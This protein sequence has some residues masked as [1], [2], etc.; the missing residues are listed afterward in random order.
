MSFLS[1]IVSSI[2][3][4]SLD[5]QKGAAPHRSTLELKDAAAIALLVGSL[6]AVFWR[7]IFTSDMFF[8]RDV[9]YYSYPHARFIQEACRQGTLP[10][11]NPYLNYGQPIL[12][13]PNFLFFYPDTLF[14]VLLPI[15]FAYT[16]HY[17]AHFALAGIGTYWLGRRWGQS[18]VAAFFAAFVFT[19]SGPVLSLGNFYNHVA[20]AAWVPWALLATDFAVESLSRRPWILLTLVFTLQFLA[21]EPFTLLATF[22]LSAAYALYQ[23]GTIRRPLAARGR[24]IL[25]VF[26]LV[27]CLMLALGAMALG[28]SLEL[29]S[30]SRRGTE[31]LRYIEITSWSFHPL[32]LLEVVVPDFFGPPLESLSLWTFVLSGRNMPYFPSFFVGF[33]PM[34]FALAGLALGRNRRRK[35]AAVAALIF[36]L[37]SFGRYTPLFDLAYLLVPPLELVRFPVKMLIPAV[38]LTAILAGWG[39]DA[40]RY[41]DSSLADRR[42]GVLRPLKWI[43]A[44]AALLLLIS[45]AAP[46]W[47]AAPAGWL[48]QETNRMS[49]YNPSGELSAE[50]IA[51]AKEFFLK[52][53]RIHMPGL[54]GFALG[55]LVWTLAL[56]VGKTW[57][58]RA[59]PG[60]VLFSLAQLVMV[61]SSANP[62]VPKSFYD[63]RPPVLAH[64]QKSSMPSRF[65]YIFRDPA[66]SPGALA[67]QK[68][69]NFD[70]IPEAA[71]LSLLAQAAFRDKILLARGSMLTRA[72][73]V[74]NIDV[75]RSLPNFLYEFWGFALRQI[76]DAARSDC[77]LGRTNLKYF[78]RSSRL[79]NPTA[80]EVAPIFNGSSQPSYLYENLCATPRA[81]VAGTGRYS[82]SAIETLT[83]MSAPEFDPQAEVVL[84]GEAKVAPPIEGS[85]AAGSVEIVE[86]Q[87]NVVTLRAELF[88]PGY[89]VLLDRFDPNW[90][91]TL[92]GQEVPI[93]RANFMFR[94]VRANAGQHLI[95]FYYRQRGLRA[96]LVLSLATFALL[97]IL[98][99]I[100]PHDPRESSAP[101]APLP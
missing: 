93:L 54:V 75:E 82:T 30:I 97:A 4:P 23:R 71:G 64:F 81:Y 17:I 65:C 47:I 55:S 39:V 2:D 99:V 22:A 15:D 101:L 7:V 32:S 43:M 44:C 8:L 56:E 84:A 91:A 24:R 14:I 25:G 88:R 95:R 3:A 85:G 27:G 96:G 72:E 61:N 76:P 94:A 78:I 11:W 21:A 92:D 74:F 58:R 35:F 59:L 29:L 6:F 57:A 31:G 48:L 87:P 9:F 77:L 26:F 1:R 38:M 40:L 13:N 42:A 73:G 41:I 98:Y 33:V 36:L 80:R 18:P 83:R 19:F 52:V 10:Y 67:E 49:L 50:E 46:Q 90:H 53:V 62:T 34:F 12:A 37:L 5:Q 16:M 70:S 20:A 86:R 100:D 69:V 45:F 89:V 79:S 51:G 63:Y 28:P 68:F 60:V 66:S